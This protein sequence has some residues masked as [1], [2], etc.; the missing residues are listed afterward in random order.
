ML[1]SRPW[2]A[3]GGAGCREGLREMTKAMS[4]LW[5]QRPEV[6]TGTTSKMTEKDMTFRRKALMFSSKSHSG[7]NQLQS[8]LPTNRATDII[9]SVKDIF[10]LLLVPVF[11]CAS[12][13]DFSE[14]PADTQEGRRDACLTLP[15]REIFKALLCGG[16]L[17]MFF[18]RVI[19][20]MMLWSFRAAMKSSICEPEVKSRR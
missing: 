18:S 13:K 10:S 2:E 15:S 14:N 5:P 11:R 12:L 9:E 6:S 1:P 7:M 20:G 3:R 17:V 4:L 16:R 19:S 8:W